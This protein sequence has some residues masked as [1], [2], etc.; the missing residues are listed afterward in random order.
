[1]ILSLDVL[2]LATLP[3]AVFALAIGVLLR[4]R[5][6]A[7]SVI[8][9]VLGGPTSFLLSVLL[10]RAS[11]AALEEEIAADGATTIS[12]GGT[13]CLVRGGAA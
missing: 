9:F 1:M 8:V 5:S 3:P 6:Y 10:M 2:A 11:G 12:D 13:G 7:I 4:P